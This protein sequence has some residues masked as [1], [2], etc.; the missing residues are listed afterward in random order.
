[1]KESPCIYSIVA[2]VKRNK[3]DTDNLTG[4]QKNIINQCFFTVWT[5]RDR[6][7]ETNQV[8][9]KRKF[10]LIAFDLN[11]IAIEKIA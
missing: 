2:K 8:K 7:T 4:E 11:Y 3:I 5:K 9:C 1:M 6:L 10:I